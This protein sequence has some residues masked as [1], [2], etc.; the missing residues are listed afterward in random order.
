MQV[1]TILV[2]LFIYLFIIVLHAYNVTAE[3]S[4]KQ[5]VSFQATGTDLQFPKATPQLAEELP[6][7]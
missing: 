2:C 1:T 6:D 4:M 3:H 5:A 7:I